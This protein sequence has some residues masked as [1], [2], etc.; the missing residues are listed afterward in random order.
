M[1]RAAIEGILGITRE[2][3][4]LR[5]APNI[6]VDWSGFSARLRVSGTLCE[7]R[8]AHTEDAFA[9]LD[10]QAIA[11]GSEVFLP[12]DGTSHD[13]VLGLHHVEAE[14]LAG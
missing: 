6:P 2:G 11:A 12:L 4:R 10:G 1:Y 14:T 3:N 9:R 8:V 13:L 7:I 5:V